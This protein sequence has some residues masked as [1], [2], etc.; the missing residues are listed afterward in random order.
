MVHN[1]CSQK[2][3]QPCLNA[4][5]CCSKGFPKKFCEETAWSEMEIYPEYRRRPPSPDAP[6]VE[7]RGRT[8]DNRWVVPYNPYLLLKFGAHI[9][10][11]VC[12]SV[13]SVKYLYKYVSI[14]LNAANAQCAFSIHSSHMRTGLQRA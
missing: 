5:G 7:H 13:E 3:D 11:E 8:L 4:E 12:I 10:V 6:P 2:R 14:A 9:N 1:D